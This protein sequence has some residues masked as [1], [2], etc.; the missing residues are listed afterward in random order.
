MGMKGW[1]LYPVLSSVSLAYTARLEVL[2]GQTI[3][4]IQVVSTS[5]F[6]EY[7]YKDLAVFKIIPSALLAET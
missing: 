5:E 4:L 7:W 3:K 6:D 2:R 1:D